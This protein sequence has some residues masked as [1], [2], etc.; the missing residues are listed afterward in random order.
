[1]WSEST[2]LFLNCIYSHWLWVYIIYETTGWTEESETKWCSAQSG[3]F[4]FYLTLN[5]LW[6]D[7]SAFLRT[8]WMTHNFQRWMS[9]FPQRWRTQ[10]NAIRNANCKTSRII[11]TL[12]AHCA[13]G[14]FLGACLSECQRTPL[15]VVTHNDCCVICV[16]WLDFGDACCPLTMNCLSI[17]RHDVAWLIWLRS[18]DGGVCCGVVCL[19][20]TFS[21]V[22]A[23]YWH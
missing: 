6:L 18:S 5:W 14:K 11:N 13:S 22:L 9:R 4:E 12:N 1:M 15:S 19:L 16:T 20:M 10:R 2:T 3:W 23:L 17:A 8:N 7:A 21:W